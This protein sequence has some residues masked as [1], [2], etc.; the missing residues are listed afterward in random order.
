M[1]DRQ[2]S[3]VM[4]RASGEKKPSWIWNAH[5]VSATI[6][7]FSE[8]QSCRIKPIKPSLNSALWWLP[9]LLWHA[10]VSRT[11]D[12]LDIFRYPLLT[13]VPSRLSA[14]VSNGWIGEAWY[15]A[16]GDAESGVFNKSLM[17]K[18]SDPDFASYQGW[19]SIFYDVLCAWTC[20]KL[21]P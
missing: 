7:N 5:R 16:A 4:P 10:L 9:A 19:H 8:S 17:R 6:R 20:L 21:T 12:I 14:A 13:Q 1:L 3:T 2:V 18:G 11:L 15:H